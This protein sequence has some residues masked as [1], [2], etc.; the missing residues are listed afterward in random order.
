MVRLAFVL[1]LVVPLQAVIGGVTVLTDL[2]PWVVAF[3]LLVSMA[4]IGV[5]VLL[6]VRLGEGD[7]P[8][9]PVVARGVRRLVAATF[10]VAWLVLYLGTVVTGTG[11][12]AGDLDA[13]RNGLDPQLLSHLHAAAVYLLVGVTVVVLVALRTGDAPPQARRAAAWLLGIEL[14]QGAVGFVQYYTDLPELL[15]GLHMLGAALVSAA[16]TWLLLSTRRRT[17]LSR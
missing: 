2:N 5:A 10:A 13:P 3:H 15:V 8:A 16:V 9:V 1:G 12:H 11:P 6:L 4:I 14:A 17:G 7:G